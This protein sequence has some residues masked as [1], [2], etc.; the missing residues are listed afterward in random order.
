MQSIFYQLLRFGEG[1][2]TV[3]QFAIAAQVEPTPAKEFLDEKAKEFNASYKV[4]DEG[5]VSYYFPEYLAR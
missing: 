5:A 2:V 1:K 4:S 3:L